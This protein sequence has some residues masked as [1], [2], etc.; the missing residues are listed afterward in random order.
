MIYLRGAVY[1][2][3]FKRNR[4]T[5]NKS[6]RTSDRAVALEREAALKASYDMLKASSM[7]SG[8]QSSINTKTMDEL[9][10]LASNMLSGMK[11]RARKKSL[12]CTATKED[13]LMLLTSCRGLCAVSGVPLDMDTKIE[14]KRVSPWM[15]S[16]D[17]MDSNKG[18]VPGN[19]RIVCYIANLAMSQF[20]E[21]ALELLLHY[22]A[23]SKFKIRKA[24]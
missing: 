12:P 4:R 16:V 3:K 10:P 21:G 13:I 14:G 8:Q 24:S 15:P 11:S 9:S 5:I 2:A 17:R 6:L 7:V 18:Y 22:Y 19:I 1:H 23:Q 20:G